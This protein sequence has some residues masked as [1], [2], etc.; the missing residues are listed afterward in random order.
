MIGRWLCK[1]HVHAW[2]LWLGNPSG[3]SVVAKR[4]CARKGCDAIRVDYWN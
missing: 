3:N 2:H 4:W 1:H